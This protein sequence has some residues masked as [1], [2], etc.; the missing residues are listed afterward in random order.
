LDTDKSY[1]TEVTLSFH[2]K[3]IVKG[4]V[5]ARIYVKGSANEEFKLVR[6]DFYPWN[7]GFEYEVDLEEVNGFTSQLVGS[8][9]RAEF[10]VRDFFLGEERSG[11]I[12]TR[13]IRANLKLHFTGSRTSVFKPGMPFSG[14]VKRFSLLFNQSASNFNFLKVYVMYDDNAP[15]T[16]EKLASARLTLKPMATLSSGHVTQL[17]DIIVPKQGDYLSSGSNE[18]ELIEWM[19]RQAQDAKYQTFR[20]S[21]VYQFRVISSLNFAA[22]VCSF[23]CFYNELV[24]SSQGCHVF[25]DP[26]HLPGRKWR[27]SQCGT[28]SRAVLLTARDFPLRVQ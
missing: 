2:D 4:N 11:F 16:G 27:R 23:I 17:P 15:L 25:E 14:Q 24:Y 7:A 19:D 9:I 6:Q 20:A 3:Q 10:I 8:L 5:T 26:S 21:G 12:E 22:I 13:V 1:K 28:A 18:D